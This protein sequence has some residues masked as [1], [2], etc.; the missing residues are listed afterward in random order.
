M[1]GPISFPD[2]EMTPIVDAISRTQKFVWVANVIAV[3]IE[4]NALNI[5]VFLL[6]NLSAFDVI[7]M[8]ITASPSKVSVNSSPTFFAS[9]SSSFRYTTNYRI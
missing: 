1:N 6:P 7:N 4:K 8:L 2:G 3:K 5:R 9:K